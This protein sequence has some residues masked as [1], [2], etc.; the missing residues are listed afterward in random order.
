MVSGKNPFIF[1]PGIKESGEVERPKKYLIGPALVISQ[2][3]S[4]VPNV[5]KIRT[6]GS[7]PRNKQLDYQ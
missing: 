2:E 5:A 7:D 3:T 6:I 4:R 1:F